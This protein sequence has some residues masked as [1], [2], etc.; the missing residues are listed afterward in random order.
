M[1]GQK[2]NKAIT[3]RELGI[4]RLIHAPREL[5][6]EA[7]TNPGH[8]S[9]WWGPSGF[10]NTISKMEVRPGGEW[11]FIM[12]GPDGT[13]YKNKHIYREVV[14]PGK[15]VLEH[16]TGPKF[17][18]T[19]IFE[20]K[21]D[22]TLVTIHSVFESAE[23]LAEVIRVF[24][25]D[26]GM[27]QNI[28]RMET[29]VTALAT[30]KTNGEAPFV[31]ERVYNAPVAIVWRALTDKEQMKQWYF[32]IPDFKAE[33]GFDFRF[34]GEGKTGEKFLHLCRITDVIENKKLRYSWQYE[35]YEGNSFVTFELF[36][37]GGKTRL[38]LTH[39][40]LETFPVTAHDDFARANFVEGW[41]YLAGT[42]LKTFVEK[43]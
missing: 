40:G 30:G 12:H 41:N 35:G 34:Y 15:L 26:E 36:A 17:L 32:D 27:K 16:V 2:E 4:S 20:A 13:D 25:A 14:K 37:E 31:I 3:G 22:K 11:E 7:W 9:Q 6:W 38:R 10:K 33:A 21:G 19:V 23:Q 29:Y 8:T 18:M 28:D 39:E 5:V 42:A 24:K 1:Q 43:N